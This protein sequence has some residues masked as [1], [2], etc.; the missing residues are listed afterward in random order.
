M[1]G[2]FSKWERVLFV[3]IQT[4]KFS[5]KNVDFNTKFFV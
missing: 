2:G 4:S 3:F 1:R 5:Q